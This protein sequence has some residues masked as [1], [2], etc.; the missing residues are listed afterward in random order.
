MEDSET[1][2]RRFM[3][4]HRAWVIEGC[5]ADL[6]E[7]AAREASQAIFLDL[8]VEL[9]IENARRRPWEPHK[10]ASKL[11]Q[12]ENLP[13]LIGWISNY[14]TREDVFSRLAHRKL[15]DSFTGEKFVYVDNS[16]DA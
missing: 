12:D 7:F 9:C 3:D 10:F 4:D 11:L 8:P 15:F 13:M 1:Q 5:Y 2:V 6:L 14:E 16:R